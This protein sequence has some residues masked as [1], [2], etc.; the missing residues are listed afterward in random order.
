MGVGLAVRGRRQGGQARTRRSSACTATARSARTRWSSTPRCGTSCRSSCV[1]SLNGGW[2]ADPQ[3]NKPGRDL[4]YTRYDIMAAGPRRPRR[5]RR[6]A[7]RH[8][9]G[10]GARAAEGRRRHGRAGQRQDRLPRPRHHRPLLQL[11][12]LNRRHGRAPHPNPLPA[13]GERERGARSGR[14][15]GSGACC[16]TKSAKNYDTGAAIR[17]NTLFFDRR[18][19]GRM[20]V[21]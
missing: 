15:R 2:T 5:I 12:N 21:R 13:S 17:V 3:R 18:A 9:P 7:G 1:I 4:G 6:E 20:R 14:V 11:R 19:A 16:K 10:P 8:P